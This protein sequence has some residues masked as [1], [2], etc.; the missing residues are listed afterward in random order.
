[1]QQTWRWFGPKDLVSIDDVAQAG[2]QGI[3]S[4]LHHVPTGAVWTPQEI[5]Q[6]QAEVSRLKDGSPSGMAWDVVES[7][8]VSE[9][10]KKQKGDWQAHLD[11]YRTSLENLAAAGIEV[12]CYNFMPVLDWTRT[13]LTYRMRNGA[14]CMRFDLADFAAFD[15]H[16]LARPGAVDDYDDALREEATRRFADMSDADQAQLAKNVVFGLPGA[17][18]SFGLDEVRAHLAEY[19]AIN[20]AQLRAHLVDFLSEVIPTAERLGLRLCCHP[21]DPPVPLLGLPRIMST[22]AQYKAVMDAVDRPANGITLCTG[23]LGARPDND[24]P[25]MMERLGDRV[26]FLHLRNVT[27]ET[28]EIRGSFFEAEHLGG[29]TDMVAVIEAALR[30]EARRRA[31][32]RADWSIPFRPDHGQDILDDL[33]RR[34]QPGYPAI[35][36]LKGLAEL[37]GV[38]AALEPR[39]DA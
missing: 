28:S 3:V 18:E 1:M 24:L 9:D 17:A 10:I 5:A 11:A 22:E 19:D 15:L 2:V 6:R 32:G 31:Q 35:G 25:G 8:P 27:R 16:I 12:I 30:E 38:I 14:T 23:S 29:D 34:A 26:H 33:G 36:R 13:D 20:E 7:L 4:A 39:V 21:D 37:R